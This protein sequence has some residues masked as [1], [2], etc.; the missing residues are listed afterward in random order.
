MDLFPAGSR[1]IDCDIP[2]NE[3]GSP[4]LATVYEA[5]GDQRRLVYDDGDE[6]W[7]PVENL[8]AA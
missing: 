5:D 4:I 8:S 6:G 2:C 3:D 1:V 7:S